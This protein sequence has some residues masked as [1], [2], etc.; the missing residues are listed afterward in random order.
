MAVSETP[1]PSWAAMAP[2]VDLLTILLVFL[3]KS[4]STDPPVRPD[5]ASFN[6]AGTTSEEPVSSVR[7]LDVTEKG[8][9]LSGVRIAGTRYY[10]EHDAE[11]VA[12]L[13]D[14]LLASP[15]RLQVR[16][17]ADVP[18]A[19]VRKVLF[20]AQEAGVQD[21]TLVAASRSSL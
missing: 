18:Y 10:L 8:L 14:P 9:F 11:L 20:T 2:M 1:P 4:W 7:A 13:Y 21:L 12:E 19:L 15:G 5:D 16:V 17:D 6:L 3:L